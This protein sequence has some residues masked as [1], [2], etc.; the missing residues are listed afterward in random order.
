M[1][2]MAL[3]SAHCKVFE[4]FQAPKK[5]ATTEGAISL[6]TKRVPGL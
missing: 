1:K 5:A 2:N 3:Q 4:S 6:R